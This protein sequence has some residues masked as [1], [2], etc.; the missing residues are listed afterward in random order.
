MK[1]AITQLQLVTIRGY[2]CDGTCQNA[3]PGVLSQKDASWN[4]ALEPF[5]PGIGITNTP[6]QPNFGLCILKPIF[7][8]K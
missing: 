6:L 7:S 1:G 5:F 2:F 4:G 3:V 8:K